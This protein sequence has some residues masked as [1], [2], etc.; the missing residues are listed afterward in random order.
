MRLHISKSRVSTASFASGCICAM[1]GSTWSI[2]GWC[3]GI[4]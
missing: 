2:T 4:R 3:C 1:R